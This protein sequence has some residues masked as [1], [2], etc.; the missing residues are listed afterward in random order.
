MNKLSISQ[1]AAIIRALVEGGSIRA[2]TRQMRCGKGT[3]LRL[4]G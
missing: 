4:L 1:R 3:V 2:I